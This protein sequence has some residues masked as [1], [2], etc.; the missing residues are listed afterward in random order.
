MIGI[1][2]LILLFYFLYYIYLSTNTTP[3]EGVTEKKPFYILWLIEIK[4]YI[5]FFINTIINFLN[6]FKGGHECHRR[7]EATE[8]A[9]THNMGGAD[10]NIF[11][12][13]TT[14]YAGDD[15]KLSDLNIMWVPFKLFRDLLQA[16]FREDNARLWRERAAE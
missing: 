14:S 10:N 3:L 8:G 2:I 9:T 5:Q 13:E 6:F 16:K 11:E 12:N 4:N 1:F 7:W 15:K